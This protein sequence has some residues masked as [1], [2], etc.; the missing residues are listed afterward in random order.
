VGGCRT[1]V[2]ADGAGSAATNPG[3]RGF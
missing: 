2:R 3:E 1:G